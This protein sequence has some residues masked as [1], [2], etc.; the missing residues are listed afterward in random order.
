MAGLLETIT[1]EGVMLLVMVGP[2]RNRLV[3][4]LRGAL[5]AALGR[6]S[7]SA[8]VRAIVVC[9]KG[10]DFSEGAG[11]ALAAGSDSD[12]GL[13]RVTQAIAGCTK[14]VVAALQG[15]VL[16]GGLELALAADARIASPDARIGFPASRRDLLPQA[17]GGQRLARLVGAENALRI[18]LTGVPVSGTTARALGLVDELAEGDVTRAAMDCALLLAEAA[19]KGI[20]LQRPMPWAGDGRAFEKVIATARAGLAQ[21][22]AGS[23]VASRIVDCV[24]SALLLPEE[25]AM[26]RERSAYEDCLGDAGAA[27]L[28]H[29]AEATEAAEVLAT[30]A[31]VGAVPVPQQIAVVGSGAAAADL[32]GALLEAGCEVLL[33]ERD[34]AAMTAGL[35][36]IATRQEIAVQNRAL[37]PVERDARWARLSAATDMSGLANIALAID[38]IPDTHPGKEGILAEID[39]ALPPLACMGSFVGQRRLSEL[40]TVT[41]RRE[42]IAGLHLHG[43][44]GV[45]RLAEIV[46]PESGAPLA[47]RMLAAVL[48]RAGIVAVRAGEG[49]GLIA[50]RL[51]DGWRAAALSLLHDGATP[52]GIDRAARASGHSFGPFREMDEAGLDRVAAR[53][54]RVRPDIYVPLLEHL[55]SAGW[56]GRRV[57]RGFFRYDGNAHR[58]DPEVNTLVIEMMAMDG[59][60][61]LRLTAQQGIRRLHLGLM[62]AGARLLE[63]KGAHRA[64]DVDLVAVQLTGASRRWGGPLHAADRIG[65]GVVLAEMRALASTHGPGWEPPELLVD[66][67]KHGMR[68]ADC[69]Q[70]GPLSVAA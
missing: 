5:I 1:D 11:Q 45:P 27:G 22:S 4:H 36:R 35:K 23:A 25:L 60:V 19:G 55:C 14:P 31:R 56:T 7:G 30:G 68:F 66:L 51:L 64:G 46:L 47:G 18:L 10:V 50:G 16:D 43:T 53:F 39:A 54:F 69:L 63:S 65:L 61:P 62:L 44:G 20:R 9:G 52:S 34:I 32:A 21:P 38:A 28:C 29:L 41:S 48:S 40:T 17:G 13:D 33:V 2:R 3:A 59:R 8:R 15:A 70:P 26:M 12:P 42:S 67:V 6:A 24:E 58:E 37:D 49:D 57:G